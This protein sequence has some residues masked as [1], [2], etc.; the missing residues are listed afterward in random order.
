MWDIQ[1]LYNHGKAWKVTT[2]TSVPEKI[3]DFEKD[4]NNKGIEIFSNI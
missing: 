2:A 4:E 3:M 1:G